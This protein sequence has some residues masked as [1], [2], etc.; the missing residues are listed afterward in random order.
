[1]LLSKVINADSL[2]DGIIQRKRSAALL[3]KIQAPRRWLGWL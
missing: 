1:V 3:T 2:P